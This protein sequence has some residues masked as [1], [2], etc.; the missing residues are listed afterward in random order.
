[1]SHDQDPTRLYSAG[2]VGMMVVLDHVCMSPSET[3]GQYPHPAFFT[4]TEAPPSETPGFNAVY[5]L[6]DTKGNTVSTKGSSVSN[7]LIEVDVW[8]K[9]RANREDQ[10]HADQIRK[11][12]TLRD[13]MELL[14]EIL[15]GQGFRVI[16]NDQAEKLGIKS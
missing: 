12:S 16:S 6:R 15:V 1:M 10:T 9:W 3:F 5:T 11:I 14:K 8:Q 7:Y 2:T 13:R 4:I